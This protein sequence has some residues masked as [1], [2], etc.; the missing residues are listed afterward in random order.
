MGDTRNIIG[1]F[2]GLIVDVVV[3]ACMK[4]V[5][6]IRSDYPANETYIEKAEREGTL[7]RSIEP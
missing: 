4:N 7:L 5:Y 1:F 2:T 3:L 6:R